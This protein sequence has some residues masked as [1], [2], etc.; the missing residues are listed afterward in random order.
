MEFRREGW[1]FGGVEF[2]KEGVLE[3]W[4]F[5]EVEYERKGV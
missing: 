1:S 5:G 4:S 2:W 3:G